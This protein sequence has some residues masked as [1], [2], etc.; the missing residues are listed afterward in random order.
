MA[1]GTLPKRRFENRILRVERGPNGLLVRL[2]ADELGRLREPERLVGD[3]WDACI[4]HFTYRLALQLPDARTMPAPLHAE[5]AELADR[6]TALGGGFWVCESGES[7]RL[8]LSEI[9][10]PE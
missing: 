7:R 9:Y 3:L 6:L 8:E 10:P 5:L 1:G 2:P 4:R